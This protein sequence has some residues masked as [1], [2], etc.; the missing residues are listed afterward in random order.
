MSCSLGSPKGCSRGQAAG[1]AHLGKQQQS[2]AW[3]RWDF[4]KETRL[5]W[6][7]QAP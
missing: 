2:G 1:R 6:W 3:P 7:E 4:P 5:P